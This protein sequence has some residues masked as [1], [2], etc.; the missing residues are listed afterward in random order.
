MRSGVAWCALINNTK[1]FVLAYNSPSDYRITIRIISF[2][3]GIPLY[4][5]SNLLQCIKM[6]VERQ[7]VIQ[8]DCYSIKHDAF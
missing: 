6:V 7:G 8:K 5:E 1:V 2:A 3:V 4:I